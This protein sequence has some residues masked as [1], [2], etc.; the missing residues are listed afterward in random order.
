M[1]IYFSQQIIELA[2]VR[3]KLAPC[4]LL[5]V[6]ILLAIERKLAVAVVLHVEKV[7]R[8]RGA[9][10]KGLFSDLKVGHL[11]VICSHLI[12]LLLNLIAYILAMINCLYCIFVRN[13]I[14]FVY[15]NRAIHELK[16]SFIIIIL[17]LRSPG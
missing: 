7:V 8:G 11:A 15:I 1:S 14:V 17:W 5:R 3:V 6:S 10:E 16:L 2:L 9:R 12:L 13:I 4:A